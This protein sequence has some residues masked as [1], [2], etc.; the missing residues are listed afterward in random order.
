MMSAGLTFGTISS[1]FGVSHGI[2][3]QSQCSA[4]VAAVI[5]SAVTPP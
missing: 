2:I 5:G 3:D 1:L 4:L